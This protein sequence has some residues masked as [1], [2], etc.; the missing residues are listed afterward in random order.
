MLVLIAGSLMPHSFKVAL[1]TSGVSRATRN[2]R[3]I[4]THRLVHYSTFGFTAWLLLL[5]ARNNRQRCA[6]LITTITLGLGVEVLQHLIYRSDFEFNDVRDDALAA[7]AVC[8]IRQ[9]GQS[10]AKSIYT[11]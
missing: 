8:L 11:T 3:I 10:R 9:L 6:A 2:A 5:V 4:R 1:G 7:C